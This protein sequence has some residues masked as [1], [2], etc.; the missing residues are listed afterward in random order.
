WAVIVGIDHYDKERGLT[1]CVGDARLMF[2]YLTKSL[3]VP[4]SHILLDAMPTRERILRALYDHLR[5]NEDIPPSGANLLFHFSGHGSSYESSFEIMRTETICPADRYG[6][7][8]ED[9]AVP[10]ISDRELNII[11]SEICRKKGTNLTV[12]LDC[13]FSGSAT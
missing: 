12:I 5:D 7:S 8:V 3:H 6:G 13:C 4:A 11:F 2:S 10:D 9:D 1:G